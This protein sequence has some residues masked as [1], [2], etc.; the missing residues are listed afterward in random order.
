VSMTTIRFRRSTGIGWRKMLFQIWDSRMTSLSDG[1]EKFQLR[2]EFRQ[3]YGAKQRRH[4]YVG[5]NDELSFHW[6]VS[7]WNT[8]LLS[9]S[10]CPSSDTLMA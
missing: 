7:S 5:T 4:G 1:I 9:T 8:R 2:D 6:P 3:T 10:N